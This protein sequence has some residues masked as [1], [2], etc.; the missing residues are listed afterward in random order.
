M[1]WPS[2]RRFYSRARAKSVGFG[3][4]A[5]CVRKIGHRVSDA[6]ADVGP[7]SIKA[8]HRRTIIADDPA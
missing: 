6:D 3:N 8:A 5:A 4:G 2:S 1:G 7:A